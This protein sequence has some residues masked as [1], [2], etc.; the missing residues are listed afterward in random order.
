[1]KVL[2]N[3]LLIEPEEIKQSK[4]GLILPGEHIIEKAKVI[5]VSDNVKDIKKDDIVFFKNW[6]LEIVHTKDKEY[7]FIDIKHIT[8]KQ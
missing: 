6:Y 2:N 5:E 1:M 4:S 7:C 8:A 3:Y